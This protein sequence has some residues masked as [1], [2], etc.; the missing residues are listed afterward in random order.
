[1]TPLWVDYQALKRGG[2]TFADSA[3]GTIIFKPKLSALMQFIQKYEILR[4][5]SAFVWRIEYQKRGLPRAHILSWSDFDTQDIQAAESVINVRYPNDSPFIE[6]RGM[7]SD[8]CQLIDAF[9]I[10]HHSK[11]CRLPNGKY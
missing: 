11:R 9:Q 5:V 1:M 2:E 3:V 7:V 8:L 10:H 4:R 6:D